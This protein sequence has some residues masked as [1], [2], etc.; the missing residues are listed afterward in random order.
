F[1]MTYGKVLEESTQ[2]TTLKSY[3][4]DFKPEFETLIRDAREFI[5]KEIVTKLTG[6]SP[7]VLGSDMS[8]YLVTK[9]F[10]MGILDSN[11][12][13]KVA[14]AYSINL[15]DLESKQVA[16]KQSGI[17]RLLFFDEI[18][19]EKHPE[20]IDRNNLHEQLLY[21]ESIANTEG[22]GEVLR[23]VSQYNNFRVQDLS[24]IINLL[25][26][27]YRMRLN[28]RETLIGKEQR[29]LKILGSLADIF[30]S[31]VKSVSSGKTLEEFMG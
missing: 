23:I 29:E 30:H 1:I 16:I 6:R 3:R 25:I 17:T 27:S 4:S 7:N 22:V 20:E 26:K 19:F 14:W 24:Q 10:Y 2:H 11:E 15:E 9:A 31:S 18:H 13:V 8:F 12:A 5:L 21:L 28:K